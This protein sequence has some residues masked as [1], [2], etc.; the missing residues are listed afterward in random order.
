MTRKEV[1]QKIDLAV[2]RPDATES[3]VLKGC[4]QAK[5][6]GV[7]SL[8]VLPCWLELIVRELEGS[9]VVPSTVI[10]FPF[11]AETTEV[12][13]ATAKWAVQVGAGELDMVMAIGQFKS[14][15][16]DYVRR[17]IEAAVEAAKSVRSDV[18]V[19]VIIETGYLTDDEKRVAAQI[20]EAAGAD[21]VKTSTGFGPKGA[22]VE[23]VKLL[24]QSVSERVKVK[25]AG[26]IRTW[27]QAQALLSAGADRLGTSSAAEIL[28]DAL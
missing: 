23:D 9:E 16:S 20:V 7:K 4:E 13:V 25:A 10:A 15:N 11:G 2:L 1:A 12:K 3:D 19:K 14:G 5:F 24:K 6:W 21:F 17:D 27:Q 18:I 8:V 22:T 26:G 28:K